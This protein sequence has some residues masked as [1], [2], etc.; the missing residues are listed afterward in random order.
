VLRQSFAGHLLSS[1]SVP[2]REPSSKGT[3]AMT[4][5]FFSWQAGKSSSSDSGRNIVDDLDGVDEAG[6]HGAN[7]IG[8]LPA[9]EAEAEGANFSAA[10]KFLDGVRHSIIFE[11]TVI[12]G[13]KLRRSSVSTPIFL[14]L[15]STYSK[16]WSGG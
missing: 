16:I 3:R 7:A 14:R 1:V 5:A 2:V 12:P 6:A 9:V 10:A 8:G 13:V 15:L 4:A 11:P